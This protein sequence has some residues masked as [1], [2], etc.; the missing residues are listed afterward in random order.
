MFPALV[1][2]AAALLALAC[3]PAAA[4]VITL[5]TRH[6]T[7]AAAPAGST[8]QV[9]QYYANLVEGLLGQPPGAGFCD[10]T[11]SAYLA[12][13]NSGTCGGGNNDIAFKFT[14]DFGISSAQA[15]TIAFQVGPDFG[16]GGAVFLDGAL[17]AAS[18]SDL[19]WSGNYG[20]AS[21]VF[22]LQ[23]IAIGAGNHR[24]SVYGLE[25]CCDGLQSA[26]Y[27]LA[28]DTGWTTFSS[29]DALRDVPEPLTAALVLAGLLGMVAVGR[30][31]AG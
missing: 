14:V 25:G 1:S 24:L 18:N 29:T 21:E 20:A 28:G 3:L 12:L 2:S 4:S 13:E 30:K 19:W 22:S 9:G 17:L 16:K 27:R 8:A 7:A 15:G 23:N 6:S 11:V 31:R 26:Q 5:Q 10:T